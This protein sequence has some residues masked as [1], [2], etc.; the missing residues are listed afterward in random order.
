MPGLPLG[1]VLTALAS[2]KPQAD[3]P[4]F[5]FILG[6]D[7][8]WADFS[9]NNGTAFSPRIKEWTQADGTIIMQDFHSGGTVCSPTR[10]TVLTGRN[11]FRD[12]VDY[13]YG[14]SDMTECVPN[15]KFAP[16]KTF[17]VGD[18]V[19]AANKNYTSFFAGK[20]HL[21]SFYNDSEAYG[22]L[23]SSPI[24]HGFDY[25]NATVEVAPTATT[26]CE[27]T[28]EWYEHCDFG[29]DG[30][31][32]HCGGHGN[33]GGGPPLKPG[34]CFN[35]WWNDDSSPHAVTNL[36]NPSP[37]ND[38]RDY[39]ADTFVRFLEARDGAPFFAQIS[40]HNCHIPFIGTPDERQK[41]N[42]T[43]SCNPPL[44]NAKPYT[45]AEL[46][47]YA[48][49]NE[50]DEAVGV[51]LDALKKEGYY[52]N[53]MIWFTTDNGPEVNCHPEG[54][55]GGGSTIPPGTLHRPAS[56]GPGSAG[57]LRGRKRD[58]WEGGHR[59]PGIIS[60]PAMVN[61]PA[62]VSWDPVITM[63]FL[64]TVMDVLDVERPAHQQHWAFD[65]VSAMP[66]IKGEAVPQ[67]GFGHMYMTPTASAKEGYS[68]RWQN[69][70]LAVGG[71]SCDP[72]Q[73]SF[74]CSKPQLYNMDNDIAENHNLADQEPEILNQIMYNFSM[75]QKSVLNSMA[76][77]SMCSNSNSTPSAK[78]PDHPTPSSACTFT[79]N[80]A[81]NGDD[82]AMGSVATQEECCG[83]CKMT[84]GC[85]AADFRPASA[86]RPTYDGLSSGGTCHLKNFYS[87]K[88]GSGAIACH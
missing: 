44:P 36:T 84:T 55:C 3:T 57:Q 53:T 83:A 39:L 65:G 88:P 71:V 75:W 28:Q 66:I 17:T 51:M 33:P 7:I 8:G 4:S 19:R 27:C 23:T 77:E 56:T 43:E 50:F 58:V 32:T 47:F 74:D 35:Y 21:G 68:Y 46:D 60:W 61:G 31:P 6:D 12:C 25:F 52:D 85:V 18:A 78:F 41:C 81:L 67:R 29:H 80:T 10:A 16:Q 2:A 22:G 86:M 37:D 69:W 82:M 26:N 20:W 62:R 70:K 63:D 42:S 76:N 24:T 11:H 1:A 34:C 45:S 48:C 14:C 13:V 87:P 40:I 15:F 9:Y 5:L 54:R 79:P 30:G 49:L 59:V 64:A 73:A 38:A 72:E